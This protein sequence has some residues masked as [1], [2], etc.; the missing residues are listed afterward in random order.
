MVVHIVCAGDNNFA[1]PMAVMLHSLF[2][3]ASKAAGYK[4]YIISDGI[5]PGN[6]KKLE[7]VIRRSR[8]QVDVVW[9]EAEEYLDRIKNFVVQ[10]RYPRTT[11]LRLFIPEIVDAGLDRVI[12]L[13][14]DMVVEQDIVALWETDMSDNIL[15]AV[16]DFLWTTV[17]SQGALAK[18]YR[19]L[20]LEPETPF[21][22]TG[23]YLMNVARY[24]ENNVSQKACDYLEQYPEHINFVDQDA[25]NAAVLGQCG[26]LDPKWNVQIITINDFGQHTEMDALQ[27][28]ARRKDLLNNPY[29]LHYNGHVKPWYLQGD[30]LSLNRFLFYLKSSGWFTRFEYSRW[31]LKTFRK[32][33]MRRELVLLKRRLLK[34][35]RK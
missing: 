10:D 4:V 6:R 25:L 32:Y 23:M 12:Y 26:L 11:Y 34:G 29:I 13:D 8:K 20:G 3:N 17:S 5:T 7:A 33:A 9:K 2:R 1:L 22:N 15:L 31:Y 27:L 18:T 24:K 30:K 21:F 19:Q 16:Q 14:G 35:L 28:I